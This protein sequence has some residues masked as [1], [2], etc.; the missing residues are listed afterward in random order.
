MYILY[1]CFHKKDPF[2]L[3]SIHLLNEF[4]IKFD[5]LPKL[6]FIYHGGYFGKSVNL[7]QFILANI[8][9]I[10]LVAKDNNILLALEEDSYSNLIY[11]ISVI[12][13]DEGLKD[14][15][16]GELRALK[17]DMDID[18]FLDNI[19][20]HVDYMPKLFRKKKERIKFCSTNKFKGQKCVLFFGPRHFEASLNNEYNFLDE[21]FD[22]IEVEPLYKNYHYY[23]HLKDI[24]P[25]VAYGKSAEI[26][27]ECIDA[28]ANFALCF[29]H[30]HFK[31][32]DDLKSAIKYHKRDYINFP[33]INA[34][35]LLLIGFGKQANCEFE[36]HK[37]KIS[38]KWGS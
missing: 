28:G 9:N 1:S 2:L 7:A 20:N 12:Y 24:N 5:F 15:I 31:I 4:N 18:T 17:I 11:A 27:Y 23:A 29:S 35:Q 14:F 3:S 26:L 16:K 8:Y 6:K 19:H 10:A 32:L 36:R 37:T 30:S 21:M 34:N 38:E 22:L 13:S 33:T 25:K